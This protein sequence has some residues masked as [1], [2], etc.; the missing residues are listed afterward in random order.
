[1]KQL[2]FIV[3]IWILGLSFSGCQSNEIIGLI[4]TEVDVVDK[5]KNDL[6]IQISGK[7][8]T[9]HT[10]LT[11]KEIEYVK[12]ES[13]KIEFI[14]KVL[15][16]LTTEYGAG[17]IYNYERTVLE[18]K[19]KET[20]VNNYKIQDLEILDLYFVSVN[21]SDSLMDVLVERHKQRELKKNK[22]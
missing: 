11:K 22:K 4:D 3:F 14:D 20:I 7:Y 15:N 13:D 9:T 2:G 17:E 8:S 6:S 16:E 18:R 5:D 10:A 19:L 21:I 12:N 1:M